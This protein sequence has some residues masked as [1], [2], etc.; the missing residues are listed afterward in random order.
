MKNGNKKNVF[1][2]HFHRESKLISDFY[3]VNLWMIYSLKLKLL[4]FNSLKLK[5]L[6]TRTLK[7]RPK[8]NWFYKN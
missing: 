7:T 2:Q 1:N 4:Y 3:R 8:F 5:V 6:I